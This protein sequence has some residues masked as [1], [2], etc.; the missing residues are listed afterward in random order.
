MDKCGGRRCV[1]YRRTS[2]RS[3][4]KSSDMECGNRHPRTGF[5]CTLFKGH[6][7][8]HVACSTSQH[9]VEKWKDE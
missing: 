3:L 6:I 2:Q 8:Y 5:V 9:D 7:G 1:D 4:F